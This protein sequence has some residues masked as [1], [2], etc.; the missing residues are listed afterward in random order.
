MKIILLSAIAPEAAEELGRTHDVSSAIDAPEAELASLLRDR[1]VLVFRS[2]VSVTAD[3]LDAAPNI[4]LI[5]RAGSGMD[6]IDLEAARRRSIRVVRVPGPSAQAV[7][8]F[9]FALMLAAMRKVALADRLVRSGRWPKRQLGGNLLHGK[10]LGVVGAGSI[11]GRVGELG[12]AWRMRVLACV[13]NAS[14]KRC[15]DYA[16]RGIT[17][18]DLET[19]VAEADVL[20]L[21]LPLEASTQHLVNKEFLARM[22][23]GAYLINTAR[24]GVVDEAALHAALESSHLAGAALDVHGNE[25]HGIPPL[26]ELPNVVLTPHIGAMALESQGEIGKR[27]VKILASFQRSAELPE[28]DGIVPVA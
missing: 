15:R 7:A 28:I 19:V 3:L 24:G 5:V 12:T 21:H 1:E 20:T 9:T 10:T 4:R 8:E 18:T 2:G 27:I 22:K 11:G 13:N 23:A 6:N 16:E 25:G 14:E 17:L 26:A